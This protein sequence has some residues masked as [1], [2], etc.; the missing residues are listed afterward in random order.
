MSLTNIRNDRNRLEKEMQI[1]SEEG[2]YM[3]NVPGPGNRTGFEEDPH[4]RL[5]KWG[6]NL[7]TNAINVESDLI[8]MSRPLMKDCLFENNYAMHSASSRELNY[9]NNNPY[10][11]QSRSTA[12]AWIFRELQNNRWNYLPL[13]PQANIEKPFYNNISTRIIEKDNYDSCKV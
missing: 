3:L 9:K 10:V 12:P 11:E 5:Q 1:M 2:R 13:D 6:A 8:G 7:H 4:I